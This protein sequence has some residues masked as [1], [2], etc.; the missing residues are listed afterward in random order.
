MKYDKALAKAQHL[1]VVKGRF[2]SC[3]IILRN[4]PHKK[5][6]SMALKLSWGTGGKY[7]N[8]TSENFW[9][10]VEN[11]AT[12][13]TQEKLDAKTVKLS[14]KLKIDH[15][16]R[17]LNSFLGRKKLLNI[18][19]K[20]WSLQ[21]CIRNPV[22]HL[23]HLSFLPLTKFANC[24]ILDDRLGPGCISIFSFIQMYIDTGPVFAWNN[25]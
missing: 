22:E 17:S 24:S 15:R 13:F 18:R 19:S 7:T 16:N 8:H 5:N 2:G 23:R 20:Y 21:R 25:K 11:S 12:T 4:V 6:C 1:L 9:L 14:K 3:Q 10:Y